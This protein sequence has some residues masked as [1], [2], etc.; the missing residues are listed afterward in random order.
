MFVVVSLICR[1]YYAV[2]LVSYN[3][4]HWLMNNSYANKSNMSAPMR[5]S[6]LFFCLTFLVLLIHLNNADEQVLPVT[7]H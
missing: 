3:T 7:L 2:A 5:I 1:I 4:E 6:A